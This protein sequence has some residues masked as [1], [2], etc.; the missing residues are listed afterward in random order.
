MLKI[1]TMK[2]LILPIAIILFAGVFGVVNAQVLSF[3]SWDNAGSNE[4]IAEIGPDAISSS[5]NAEAQPF[6]NGSPQG[7]AP[8]SFT[9]VPSGFCC[10]FNCDP[11][12]T[13]PNT[14]GRENIELII[15]NPGNIFDQPEIR[16]SIDYRRTSNETEAYFFSREPTISSG[17][18]FRMGSNYGRFKVEFSTANGVNHDITLFNYWGGALPHDIPND[19]VWRNYAFEYIQAT[20]TATFYIDGVTALTSVVAPPGTAM[21]WPSTNLVIGPN[22]DNE[23]LD[24]A[25][26]DNSE[27]SI[28][29]IFPVV[30]SY[31]SGEQV[32]LRNRIDWG[33]FVESNSSHFNITR[34]DPDG[35]FE[36][37]GRLEAAGISADEHY[38]SFFDDNPQ[39]GIN[40]YRL[41]QVDFEGNSYFSPVVQ[42]SF[43]IN[44][45]GLVAVYPNPVSD[46]KELNVK[47]RAGREKSLDLLIVD[48]QGRVVLQRTESITSEITHLLIPTELLPKG[49][50][51]CRVAA[52]GKSWSRKFIKN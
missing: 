46:G 12:C 19:G 37:I 50:Y 34:L 4:R 27:V 13:V 42:V 31:M 52:G 22:M 25:I 11:C 39:P 44:D 5:P 45:L 17:P 35:E 41:E 48:L 8:G 20:G 26:L 3:F 43:N 28:P 49:M 30:Y 2:N 47:F 40:F 7:L 38:Y 51:I 33:T 10:A 29:V 16:F 15:P 32:G 36:Y 23:G 1:F 14:C 21:A 6:G 18:R 9:L 24:L